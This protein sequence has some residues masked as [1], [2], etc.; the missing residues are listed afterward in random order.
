MT[1]FP[2]SHAQGGGYGPPPS[3]GGYGPPPG[4]G[5]YGPPP[6]GGG[7]GPPPGAPPGGY[8]PPPGAPPGGGYGPPPGGFGGPP[9]G[10]FGGPPGFPGAGGPNAELRKQVTT[11]LIISLVTFFA[12][13]N[14]CF[15]G[16][17]AILCFLALQAVDQGNL[18]DAESKLKTGKMIT[19]GGFVL[20]M[21][22]IIAYV[23]VVVVASAS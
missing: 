23:I 21:L 14:G 18:A 15:G 17:G 16:I 10:G 13:G 3:G 2:M 12:C 9:P 1:E 6:G 20:T 11:W 8:G 22:A 7:Y 19:I 4:G 5:G